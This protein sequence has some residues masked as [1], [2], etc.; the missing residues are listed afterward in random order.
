MLHSLTHATMKMHKTNF[1]NH[2]KVRFV[3]DWRRVGDFGPR[4]VEDTE[5]GT[6]K[7]LCA[8][9]TQQLT[10]T[11]HSNF[12]LIRD[13]FCVSLSV[14]SSAIAVLRDWVLDFS[15]FTKHA[16]FTKTMD[17]TTVSILLQF[18]LKFLTAHIS[19]EKAI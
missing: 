18:F 5:L 15:C 3:F 11:T 9:D 6:I 17:E 8:T 2:L 10:A 19:K 14:T 12:P 13:S 16:A 4:V 1:G 7:L